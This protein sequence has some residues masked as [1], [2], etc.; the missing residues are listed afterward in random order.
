MVGGTGVQMPPFSLGFSA[1][2][3]DCSAGTQ[4]PRCDGVLL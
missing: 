1:C 4:D 3:Y 2:A